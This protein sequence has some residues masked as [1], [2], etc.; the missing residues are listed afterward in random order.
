MSVCVSG[1]M[2]VVYVCVCVR[3]VCVCVSGVMCV[4]YLCVCVCVCVSSEWCVCECVR[5]YVNIAISCKIGEY[6]DRH[7]T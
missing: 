4:V 2:C 6:N 1:V 3:V 5:V 7:F